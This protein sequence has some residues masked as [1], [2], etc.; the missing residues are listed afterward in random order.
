MKALAMKKWFN[1]NYHYMAPEIEDSCCIA[2]KG[3]K[4]FDEFSE[5]RELGIETKPVI[6]GAYTLLKLSR[7]TGTCRAEDV[8]THVIKAYREITERFTA[9]NAEWIQFDEPALVKDMTGEDIRLFKELYSGILDQKTDLKVFL[10]TY[11]WKNNYGKTLVP[12]E[13]IKRKAGYVV[14]GTSCSLL[15]VPCTEV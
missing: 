15:H 6:T 8:K 7:F 1:T 2:L 5:A 11:I 3:T 4:P 14:L 10:Q 12:L 9:E 13:R